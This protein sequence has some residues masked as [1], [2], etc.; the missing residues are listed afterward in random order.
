GTVSLANWVDWQRLNHSFEM[1]A[2]WNG[3]A[4][5]LVNDGDPELI[6]G[7]TVSSE[8][9]PA[10]EIAPALGRVFT[11]DDDI[12]N[13]RPI[14]IL[15]DRLWKRRFGGDPAIVGKK[16]ELD[17]VSRE[18]VGVMPQGFY[19]LNP[20]AEYWTPYGLDRNSENRLARVIPSILGRMKPGVPLPTVQA[21]MRT[22]GRQLEQSHADT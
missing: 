12:P 10:L 20:A 19:F 5:T 6:F 15:S 14:V 21:E 22:I 9:F 18:V 1:L 7:Q 8:F 16:I 13:G 11:A 3:I 4:A 2:A 17:T